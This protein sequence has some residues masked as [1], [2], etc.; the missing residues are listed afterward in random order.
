MYNNR[1]SYTTTHDIDHFEPEMNV[2][3][4]FLKNLKNNLESENE[5]FEAQR[6]ENK[7]DLNAHKRARE[8]IDDESFNWPC[9]LRWWWRETEKIQKNDHHRKTRK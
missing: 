2:S 3:I 8:K 6:R 1:R 7:D 4:A 9:V 5:I